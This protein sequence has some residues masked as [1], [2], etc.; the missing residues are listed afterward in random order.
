MATFLPL[1]SIDVR[2]PY[3]NSSHAVPER[4]ESAPVC[5][6]GAPQMRPSNAM[7]ESGVMSPMSCI[8]AP[9]AAST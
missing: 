9:V 3:R 8:V 1:R 4:S 5:H 6:V 2:S 7:R